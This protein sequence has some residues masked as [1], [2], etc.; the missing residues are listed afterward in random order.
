MQEGD[1][2]SGHN[3]M[4]LIPAAKLQ[5]PSPDGR[6]P[7]GRRDGGTG[8]R[9]TDHRTLR[10]EGRGRR[11]GSS[12]GTTARHGHH[13]KQPSAL[14]VFL[15]PVLIFDDHV[16][17]HTDQPQK[18]AQYL[19]ASFFGNLN[20]IKSELIIQKR[21]FCFIFHLFQVFLFEK[22]RLSWNTRASC[23][24]KQGRY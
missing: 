10:T 22:L 21:R 7:R 14:M 15:C 6:W 12:G 1:S 20:P 11:R 18:H 3:P 4:I 17:I 9:A 13:P 2:A 24:R 19:L 8:G 5:F 23:Y 16:R